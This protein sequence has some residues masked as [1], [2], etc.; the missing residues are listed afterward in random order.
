MR[1]KDISSNNNILI[2]LCE[3]IDSII[4]SIVIVVLVERQFS[5]KL[6]KNG[7]NFRNSDCRGNIKIIN[8]IEL[9][10]REEFIGL[11]RRCAYLKTGTIYI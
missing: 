1:S 4:V 5:L 6:T 9:E 11:F 7:W 3:W 2:K 10:R 8:D